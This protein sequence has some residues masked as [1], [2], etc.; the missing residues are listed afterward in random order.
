MA[1]TAPAKTQAKH[2][3]AQR[4]VLAANART[5]AGTRSARRLRRDGWVPGVVYGKAVTSTTVLVSHRELLKFLHAHAG[6]HGLLTLRVDADGKPWEKPVLIKRVER[7]PVKGDVVHIDFHAIALTEQIRIKIPLVLNGTPVGVKQDGGLL[8]HFLREAEVECLPTQ[9]PKQI[10]HDI[11]AMKI[12]DTLHVRDLSAPP[13]ARLTS[14]PEGVVA[15]VLLPKVEKVEEA[16]AEAVTEPEV[17]REK[18]PEAEAQAP[19][20]KE[21]KKAE[22]KAEKKEEKKEE[23]G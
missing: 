20:G 5:A 3:A 10:E 13:G 1:R 2:S 16:P 9:I 11:S 19:E 21:E 6:E 23:K 4:P 8:E 17:I 12:G 14:D 22:K 7:D 18:K 15:S